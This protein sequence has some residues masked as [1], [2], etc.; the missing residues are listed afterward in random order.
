MNNKTEAEQINKTLE[1]IKLKDEAKDTSSIIRGVFLIS[2]G[3]LLGLFI[4]DFWFSK[5]YLTAEI[6]HTVIGFILGSCLS[7]IITSFFGKKIGAIANGSD[8]KN[9][10]VQK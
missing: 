9:K 2:G 1:E 3:F 4:G 5:D 8:Q 6:I 7:P 10:E